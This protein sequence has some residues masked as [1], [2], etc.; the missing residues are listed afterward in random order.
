M[1]TM[2]IFEMP[3]IE[4]VIEG[5][6]TLFQIPA[7]MEGR[8]LHNALVITGRTIGASEPFRRLLDDLGPKA[9]AVHSRVEAHNP[10]DGIAELI[11]TA[12]SSG[13][14]VVIGI[15]GGSAIDA[16]KLTALGIS[17]GIEQPDELL[18]YS[19]SHGLPPLSGTPLPIIAVPTTLSA[20][21]WNGVAAFVD[22]S[23]RRKELARYLELTPT[24]IVLDPALSALTPRQLWTTTGVR[25]I[26]H[27]VEIAYATNAHPYTTALCTAAL[28]ILARDL[29]RTAQDPQDFEA[30]LRCHQAAWMSLIGVHNVPVGL[31]HAI[32]HQLGAA[33]VPHGVTSCITLP[34]VMRFFEPA[35]EK[36]QAVMARVLASARGSSAKLPAADEM[37]LLFAKLGVPTGIRD[38]DLSPEVLENVVEATMG[39]AEAVLRQAP[40]PVSAGDVRSILKEAY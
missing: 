31:S 39:E 18:R 27:S 4:R 14:D 10:T 5:A 19:I 2:R 1:S 16:A 13:A 37:E 33:G 26:D 20:A 7:E 8:G 15:G 30:A 28:E 21:E 25:A 12:R 24:S 40:R 3:R 29:P 32:G 22:K 9:V 34:H 11:R 35:T 36:Q 38:F 17:E 23:T 6:G